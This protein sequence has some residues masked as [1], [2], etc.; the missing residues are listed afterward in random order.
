[1]SKSSRS[2]ASFVAGE[3]ESV[4]DAIYIPSVAIP[5][6]KG[7]PFLTAYI[8]LSLLLN[9]AIVFL[10]FSFLKTVIIACLKDLFFSNSNSINLTIT[11]VSVSE[12]K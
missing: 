4:S 7:E 3:K 10:P 6:T 2:T 9:N 8:F 11:S 5:K 1:M 12:T